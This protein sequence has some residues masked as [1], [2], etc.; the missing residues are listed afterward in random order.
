M[1]TVQPLVITV[2]ERSELERRARVHTSTQREARRARVI[3][4]CADGAPL[5]Q[6]AGLVEMDEHHVGVWR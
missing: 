3:W 5:C 6:I 4:R 1:F 2:E